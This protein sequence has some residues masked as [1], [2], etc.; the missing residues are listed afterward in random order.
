MRIP[1][2]DKF[3]HFDWDC[4]ANVDIRFRGCDVSGSG[5]GLTD[6]VRNVTACITSQD[7][8]STYEYQCVDDVE[9]HACVYNG[10]LK[11]ASEV[12][13]TAFMSVC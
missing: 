12:E 10:Q 1:L 9:Y 13:Y 8:K 11:P 3:G 2:T 6:N 7:G 5:K 4:Y